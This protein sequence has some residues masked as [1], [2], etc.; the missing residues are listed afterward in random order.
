MKVMKFGGSVLET[1]ADIG[2]AVELIKAEKDD[3]VVVVSAL[4][5]I[6]DE[7]N[8]FLETLEKG[9]A[10]PRVTAES[11]REHHYSVLT[12]TV[13]DS[14]QINKIKGQLEALIERWERVAFGAL[15]TEELT[16]RSRDFLM[17]LGERL[18]V[19][20]VEGALRHR[21]VQAKAI[22]MDRRGCVTNGA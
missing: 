15:Y 8:T 4:N 6:T 18:A 11:I 21:G 9:T 7:I 13:M 20:I 16:K 17:S 1:S 2:R 12:D 3:K 19:I 10:Q 14:T 5:G 22:E